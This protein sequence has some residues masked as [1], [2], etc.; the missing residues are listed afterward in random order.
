M[1]INRFYYEKD[2]LI[3]N[4]SR[5]I[6]DDVRIIQI[7]LDLIIVNVVNERMGISFSFRYAE[8]V[9]TSIAIDAD[10]EYYKYK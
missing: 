10:F 6:I 3:L 9:C 2:L 1:Y 8:I 7:C 4:K 5:L